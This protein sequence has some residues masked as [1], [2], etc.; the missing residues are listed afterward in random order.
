MSNRRV[1]CSELP[2]GGRCR[3]GRRL[4]GLPVGSVPQAGMSSFRLSALHLTLALLTR[5]L[6][7]RRGCT[8]ASFPHDLRRPRR[9]TRLRSGPLCQAP[10]AFHG[11][12]W[13]HPPWSGSSTKSCG[14]SASPDKGQWRCD[15]TQAASTGDSSVWSFLIDTAT[16]TAEGTGLEEFLTREGKTVGVQARSVHDLERSNTQNEV[17]TQC[18]PAR[19]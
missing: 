13:G 11:G 19:T 18:I 4:R 17:C 7:E 14:I 10:R 16:P 2:D 3:R 1:D 6:G 8:R 12:A 9:F 15:V 5:C